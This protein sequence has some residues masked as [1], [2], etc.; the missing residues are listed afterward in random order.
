MI[1][2]RTNYPV[3]YASLDHIFPAGTKEDN[4]TS[5]SFIEEVETF[6]KRKINFLDLGCSGGQLV[7]DFHL[8][9]HFALGLEGSDYSLR[10]QRANWPVYANKVLFTC[11]LT[12]PFSIVEN[13]HRIKFDCISAWE[14][15]EH[16]PRADLPMFFRN[17]A[18]HLKPEGL[19]CGSV[20]LIDNWVNGVNLHQTIFPREIWEQELIPDYFRWATYPFHNSINNSYVL[21]EQSFLICL[22]PKN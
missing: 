11:D 6:F 13:G 21:S 2:I 14:V 18:D 19:F 3:A 8:R 4:N 12:H 7:V 5:L 15:L 16:I 17:I 1:E 20:S 10:T 9:G 22:R